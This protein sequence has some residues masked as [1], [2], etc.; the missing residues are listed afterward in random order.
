MQ[1]YMREKIFSLRDNFVINDVNNR[2]WF[3]GRAEFLSLGHKLHLYDLNG[4]EVAYI[5]Q[6]LLTLLPQY[7][8]WQNG[9][10]VATLHKQLAFFHDRFV[11]DAWN[12]QYEINGDIWSWNYTVAVNGYQVAQVSQQWS[13][14]AEHYVMDIADNA[15]IPMILCF[16]IVIDEIKDDR[17]R[18]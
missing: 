9:Q 5:H 18:R 1:F 12:G 4:N 3:Q 2:P 15:D 16:A 17:E 8:I 7:E 14:L 13:L 6:K 10:V 11:V